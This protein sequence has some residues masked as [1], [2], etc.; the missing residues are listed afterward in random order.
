MKNIQ[1]GFWR[2]MLAIYMVIYHCL[3]HIYGIMTAGYIGVDIFAIFSG[4]F[5]AVSYLKMEK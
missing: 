2:F 3:G 5:L 4:Y 1:I